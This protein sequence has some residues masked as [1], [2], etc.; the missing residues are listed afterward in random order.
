MGILE[1]IEKETLKYC[2]QEV[3]QKCGEKNPKEE[4]VLSNYLTGETRRTSLCMRCR[5]ELD[6]KATKYVQELKE[7]KNPDFRELL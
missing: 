6:S 7:G 5:A 1:E 4:Q 2:E 3:C